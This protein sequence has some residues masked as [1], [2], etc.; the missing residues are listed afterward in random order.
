MYGSCY[1][2]YKGLYS[3]IV[4]LGLSGSLEG[5]CKLSRFR[6]VKVCKSQGGILK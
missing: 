6:I 3:N 1:P 4:Y 5:V 2:R